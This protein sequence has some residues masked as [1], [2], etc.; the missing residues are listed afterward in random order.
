MYDLV[1]KVPSR[2]FYKTEKLIYGSDY[3]YIRYI[4]LH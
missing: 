4:W 1:E 3:F 2:R